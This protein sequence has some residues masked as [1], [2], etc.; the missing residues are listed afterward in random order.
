VEFTQQQ[1]QQKLAAV[2]H[3]DTRP[4]PASPIEQRHFR[5]A[6]VELQ[7]DIALPLFT[8]LCFHEHLSGQ[9]T[10]RCDLR[11]HNKDKDSQSSSAL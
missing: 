10:W 4:S 3:G 8:N 1:L 7:K 5:A 9:C 6:K 2:E 11:F